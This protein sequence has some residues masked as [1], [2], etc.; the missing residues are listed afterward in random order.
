M[1][2]P[3]QHRSASDRVRA[4]DEAIRAAGGRVTKVRLS[5][6]AARAVEQ[7]VEAGFAG[8]LTEVLNRAVTLARDCYVP[9]N[10]G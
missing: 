3:R 1:P 8:T 10:S 4:H 7:L 6:D 2:R 9:T 5:P